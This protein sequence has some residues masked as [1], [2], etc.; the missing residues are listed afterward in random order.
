[1]PVGNAGGHRDHNAV[2]AVPPHRLDHRLPGIARAQ[3]FQHDASR[4]RG[5]A[6]FIA[7]APL[8]RY[9]ASGASALRCAPVTTTGI[10]PP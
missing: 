4:A 9:A 2:A 7:T 10:E 3:R 8:P 1:M 5:H 6:A